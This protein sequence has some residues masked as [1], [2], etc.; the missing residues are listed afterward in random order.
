MLGTSISL[1]WAL[2]LIISDLQ[3]LLAHRLSLRTKNRV[4]SEKVA[5]RHMRLTNDHENLTIFPN[6]VCW[7]CSKIDFSFPCSFSL[8]WSS[9]EQRYQIEWL[10]C[11]GTW[12]Q[13]GTLGKLTSFVVSWWSWL[14][15]DIGEEKG[16]V[17]E[18]LLLLFLFLA[19]L[20]QRSHLENTLCGKSSQVMG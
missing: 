18:N 11:C 2:L 19:G 17:V 7:S 16:R 8:S 10:L 20:A 15:S 9:Q 12:R 5:G 13:M 14:Q 4:D 3:E 1:S 6:K